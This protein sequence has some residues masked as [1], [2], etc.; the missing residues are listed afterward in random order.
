MKTCM[1]A[2]LCAPPGKGQAFFSEAIFESDLTVGMSANLSVMAKALAL[3]DGDI[4]PFEKQITFLAANAISFP[5]LQNP[6]T[7]RPCFTRLEASL[8]LD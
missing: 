3:H 5:K 7:K 8:S 1:N 4:Q 2:I 6:L